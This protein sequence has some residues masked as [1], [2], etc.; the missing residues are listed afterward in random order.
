MFPEFFDADFVG[1]LVAGV[2]PA[3]VLF[4]GVLATGVVVTAVLATGVLLAGVFFAGDLGDLLTGYS[5]RERN[6]SPPSL[7]KS[8]VIDQFASNACVRVYGRAAFTLG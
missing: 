6:G 5:R 3:C 4:A 7:V 2:S 1:V 8:I